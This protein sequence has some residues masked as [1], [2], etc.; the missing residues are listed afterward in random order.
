VILVVYN[1]SLEAFQ[2]HQEETWKLLLTLF[3]V[4]ALKLAG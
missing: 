2:L 1:I 3:W 4:I